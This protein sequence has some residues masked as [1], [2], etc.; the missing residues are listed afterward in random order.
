MKKISYVYPSMMQPDG[1]RGGLLSRW[2]EASKVG[3]QYIEVPCNCIKNAK[4]EIATGISPCQ[5]LTPDA[6]KSLYTSGNNLPESLEY[7]LH[8]EPSFSITDAKGEQVPAADLQWHNPEWVKK[9]GTMI[10]GI[11]E[12]L[13]KPASIIEIHP[14]SNK[15]VTMKD[16]AVSMKSLREMY[17]DHFNKK[18]PRIVLENRN[19]ATIA[20]CVTVETG[21]QLQALWTAMKE[22]VPEICDTC[23]I[24]LDFSVMFNVARRKKESYEE[25]LNAVPVEGIKG[26]HVHK[27]HHSPSMED[28]VPW[29][30]AFKKA[31][32]IPHD[33]FVN[34]EIH[35]ENKIQSTIDF[36]Q[37]R[38]TE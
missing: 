35:Q 4:E 34:P 5:M 26:I 38:L 33:I 21:Q 27:L 30:M 37:E 16:I 23:G 28:D 1:F 13:G 6:I 15:S 36:C 3:C 29:E 10:I 9:F 18:Y 22:T 2:E 24:V 20:N 8:T 25:Y 32:N 7:I 11:S 19:C 14:G 31:R 17:G 12:R